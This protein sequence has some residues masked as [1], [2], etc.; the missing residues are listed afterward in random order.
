[1]ASESAP[2]LIRFHIGPV[3]E[4]I[5]QARSTRD[6]WSG[7][8]LLSWLVAEGIRQLRQEGGRMIFPNCTRASQPLIEFRERKHVMNFKAL[9]TPNLPNI[10]IARIDTSSPETTAE[11]VSKA[12][13]QEWA[14][15]SEAVW[16]ERGRFGLKDSEKQRFHDQVKR[17]LKI[18]WQATSL[19]GSS[20]ADAY[21][22]NVWHLD[23]ARQTRTFVAWEGDSTNSDKSHPKEKDSITGV[24]QALLGGKD[25]LESIKKNGGAYAHLF[26]HSDYL[27]ATSIIKRVWHVAMLKAAMNDCDIQG[28]VRDLRIRSIP[29]I[30]ARKPTLDDDEIPKLSIADENYI[31]A[32]AFDGDSIGRWVNGEFLPDI[33]SLE[34]H[35][36]AFSQALS[37]FALGRVRQIVEGS[38]ADQIGGRWKG[39]LIYAGG[40]DVLCLV[41]ADAALCVAQELREAFRDCMKSTDSK[42]PNHK[43]DASAGI[44]IGHVHAPLQDLIREAQRAEKRAKVKGP[45]PAVSVSIMRRSGEVSQWTTQWN[46]GGL[47][48]YQ[49]IYNLMKR[50]KLSGKFPYRVCQLL[51]PYL[52]HQADD[53]LKGKDAILDQSTAIALIT[54]EFGHATERQ[55]SSDLRRALYVPLERYLRGLPEDIQSLLSAVIGLCT[56]V[57]FAGRT[58]GSEYAASQQ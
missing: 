58:S 26:K 49:D 39:Q 23:A 8:Y 56:T 55:G 18:A 54:H 13:N 2:Y 57:A 28:N 27:S 51:A 48:L 4:F 40:D 35:H 44:A 11:A 10:F 36:A 31:A 45:R 34:E 38:E 3:Q 1:M 20:Y 16:N 9:L 29:A 33:S 7:S 25:F 5:A 14:K 15:I 37:T 6:L 50:K 24:E 41:P 32:I 21:H 19:A 42:D 30:A 47:E 12:I 46:S 22:L 17:H 52:N 43:P 53:S